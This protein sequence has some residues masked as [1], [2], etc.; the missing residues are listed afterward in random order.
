VQHLHLCTA[1][2][3]FWCEAIYFRLTS[4][5]EGK[6]TGSSNRLPFMHMHRRWYMAKM[7]LQAA[8]PLFVTACDCIDMYCIVI[9]Y[10]SMGNCDFKSVASDE[11]VEKLLAGPSSCP[12]FVHSNRMLLIYLLYSCMTDGPTAWWFN[13]SL[14]FLYWVVCW[15]MSLAFTAFID[16]CIISCNTHAVHRLR[17]SLQINSL[18]QQVRLRLSADNI[19]TLATEIQIQ[20]CFRYW[21]S[22]SSQCT[23]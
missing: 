17:D 5:S 9:L 15:V 1:R 18:K 7:Q 8:D 21:N 20:F 23:R 19:G 13:A 12:E 11:T 10:I 16:T 22:R 2:L 6:L 4:M 3:Y 14:A